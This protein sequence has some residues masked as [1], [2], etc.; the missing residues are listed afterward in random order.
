[1]VE[2][3][4]LAHEAHV[5]I[6][7][8]FAITA[9][10]IVVWYFNDAAEKGSMMPSE[11]QEESQAEHAHGHESH[12]HSM[13]TIPFVYELMSEEAVRGYIRRC[14]GHH[15][16]QAVFSTFMDTLTQICFTEQRVRST[17]RWSEGT[18]WT[19]S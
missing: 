15:V 9:T 4:S 19:Q 13:F 6:V 14:E 18:S 17:I 16:Q 12:T 8:L 10:K 1:M 2:L 5:A 7:L 3:M 11:D